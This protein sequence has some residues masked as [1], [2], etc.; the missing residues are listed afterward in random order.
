VSSLGAWHPEVVGGV[1]LLAAGY[2]ALARR[3]NPPPSTIARVAF[4]GALLA[5]LVALNGPLHDLSEASLFS[6]HMVQHLLLTLVVPPLLLVGTP[7]PM[8]D[9]I[10]ARAVRFRAVG[11]LA[12]GLTRPVPALALYT[13]ALVLWHLPRPFDAALRYHGLH[14]VE[15]LSFLTTATLAWWPVLARSAIVPPLHY[16]P[17]LLYLFAFGIPMTLVAAM[18]TAADEVLYPFYAKTS[19]LFDLTALADQRLGGLLMWVPAGLIPLAA[20]T[21]VFFRWAAAEGED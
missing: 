17:Q 2:V 20:F 12:H 10:L 21:A 1:A 18:V 16:G 15:H 19:G 7:A 9:T 3:V 13:V 4:A 11:R 8:L 14:V 5:I 6:A